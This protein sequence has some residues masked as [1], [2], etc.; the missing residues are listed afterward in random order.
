[1]SNKSK[2]KREVLHGAFLAAMSRVASTVCIVTTAGPG[3]RKGSTVSAMSS[4]S[5]DGPRPILLVCLHRNGSLG[6]DILRN[7]SFCVNVLAE[8]QSVLS[9]I[10]AGRLGH[11]QAQRFRYAE[12]R[13]M[14]NGAP[15]L[16][17][18]VVR[19]GCR[20]TSRESVG[21]HHVIFGA[22]E[23][24]DLPDANVPLIYSCRSYGRP[25][26]LA[27]P[28]GNAACVQKVHAME[29]ALGSII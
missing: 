20:V 21:T 4:V 11:Q 7:G 15:G 13:T 18:A 25:G 23:E 3:G 9:D 24:I 16:I 22:V 2:R 10:F 12:W 26:P 28:A 8:D 5:A 14:N 6:G 1:M 19:F 29:S 17:G 27:G